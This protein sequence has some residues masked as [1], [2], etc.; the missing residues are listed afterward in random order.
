M[1]VLSRKTGEQIVVPGC[2][3]TVTVLEVRGD[4][5]RIGVSAPAHVAVH[6]REV[7]LRLRRQAARQVAE[8]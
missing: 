4:N 7:W 6:R 5:V 8:G 2:Q 1:L 3:V